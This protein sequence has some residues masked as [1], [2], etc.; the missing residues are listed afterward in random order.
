MQHVQHVCQCDDDFDQV[1]VI[2]RVTLISSFKTNKK[3]VNFFFSLQSTLIPFFL[4]PHH[5]LFPP[6][7]SLPSVPSHTFSFTACIFPALQRN[8]QHT[9]HQ[10]Q[11]IADALVP[12]PVLRCYT[13]RDAQPL[14]PQRRCVESHCLCCTQRKR[15]GHAPLL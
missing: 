12:V 1:D 4:P 7:I 10:H 14:H 15:P 2:K 6:H 11:H 13:H 8:S 9:A 5:L 3:L